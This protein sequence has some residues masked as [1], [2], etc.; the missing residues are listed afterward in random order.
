MCTISYT[1]HSFT[2]N[3]NYHEIIASTISYTKH[4]IAF[5]YNYHGIM[6]VYY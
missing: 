3:Y 1:M 4:S 6:Y 5:N 2:F